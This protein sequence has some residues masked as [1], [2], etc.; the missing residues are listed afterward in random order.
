MANDAATGEVKLGVEVYQSVEKRNEP[1]TA[2]DRT[3]IMGLQFWQDG[4]ERR[5]DDDATSGDR[6][7]VVDMAPR[8]F[9][10]WFPSHSMKQPE[11]RVCAWTDDSVFDVESDEPLDTTPCFGPGHG[12]AT[13][14]YADGTLYLNREGFNYFIDTRIQPA[15]RPDYWKVY[16]SRT[17][18]FQDPP[19]ALSELAGDLY[20]TTLADYDGDGV[21]DYDEFEF[22]HLAIG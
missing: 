5:M 18:R 19:S 6:V 3:P 14:T 12:L 15:D 22:I 10:V 21:A 9:E 17:S 2:F 7:V 11:L 20:L 1:V 4:S 8:P 13:T 16:I